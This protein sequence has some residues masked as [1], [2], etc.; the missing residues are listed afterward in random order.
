MSQFPPALNYLLDSEDRARSYKESIDNNGGIVIA[1]I[2]SKSWPKAVANLISIP[3]SA[4]APVVADFYRRHYWNR[5]Q[6]GGVDTQDIADRILDQQ[7][8]GN[9]GVLV[10]QE[11]VNSLKPGTLEKDGR[12]GPLSLAAINAIE[13]EPML[14]ALRAA[15]VEFYEAVLRLHPEDEKYRR[16]WM[17]RAQ[18]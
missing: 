16:G 10:A 4:R 18:R 17:A 9:N 13:P 3:T 5:N 11:A 8:N 7:V 14:D 15:R 1:G 2:N 6:L 12:M